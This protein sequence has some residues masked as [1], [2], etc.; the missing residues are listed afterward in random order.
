MLATSISLW[1]AAALGQGVSLDATVMES[2]THVIQVASHTFCTAA[3]YQGISA[4]IT[5]SSLAHP[6]GMAG[7]G[8]AVQVFGMGG[9]SA[10]VGTQATIFIPVIRD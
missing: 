4:N 1:L 9:N 2:P 10:A 7:A 5:Q 8:V 3:G 6:A